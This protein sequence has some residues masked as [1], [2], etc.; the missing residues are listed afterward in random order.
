MGHSRCRHVL[1]VP[2]LLPTCTPR[3][4]FLFFSSFSLSSS[5]H[6][7]LHQIP[8]SVHPPTQCKI[9][10][11]VLQQHTR[12]L[13]SRLL[14]YFNLGSGGSS[15]LS[16]CWLCE[17]KCAAPIVP[18]HIHMVHV[19]VTCRPS[20]KFTTDRKSCWDRLDLGT[21]ENAPKAYLGRA[22]LTTQAG[23]GTTSMYLHLREAAEIYQG[24]F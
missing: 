19:N 18:L 13:G 2:S 8:W 4:L 12:Q 9:I 21:V 23:S 15:F 1:S 6:S 17:A 5:L 22:I 14:G 10:L 7:H 24:P 20:P 16:H 11:F 3:P